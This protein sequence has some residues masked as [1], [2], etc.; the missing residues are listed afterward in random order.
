M[1]NCAR[2]NKN[3]YLLGYLS[4]L[5]QINLFKK[6]YMNFFEVGHAHSDIDAMFRLISSEVK[7]HNAFD[8][9]EI[10]E[11][12]SRTLPS[13]LTQ[14]YCKSF[15]DFK[16]YFESSNYFNNIVGNFN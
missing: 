12:V 9:D 7:K 14:R 4:H 8:V 5:V 11:A 1:D 16:G 2:E 13:L 6:V 15:P 10:N 3:R